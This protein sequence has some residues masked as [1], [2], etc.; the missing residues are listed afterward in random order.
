MFFKSFKSGWGRFW[1]HSQPP[2]KKQKS[3]LPMETSYNR[4]L[5][6]QISAWLHIISRSKTRTNK[7]TRW[8]VVEITSSTNFYTERPF[9]HITP[10]HSPHH[11]L[12]IRTVIL[13]GCLILLWHHGCLEEGQFLFPWETHGFTKNGWNTSDKMKGYFQSRHQLLYTPNS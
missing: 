13:Y 10:S 4:R 7:Q 3:L 11:C 1:S 9:S 8:W 5:V 2:H 12:G 6:L